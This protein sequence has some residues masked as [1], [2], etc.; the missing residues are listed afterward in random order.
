VSTAF[1][2]NEERHNQFRTD[3]DRFFELTKEIT[4]LT[5]DKCFWMDDDNLSVIQKIQSESMMESIQNNIDELDIELNQILKRMQEY[6][7][8]SNINKLKLIS[9]N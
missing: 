4:R 1:F 5:L 2:I 3:N 7:I 8:V 6:D 9:L